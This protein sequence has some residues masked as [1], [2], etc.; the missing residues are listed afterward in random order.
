[1]LFLIHYIVLRYAGKYRPLQ[2]YDDQY[3]QAA[4]QLVS[5]ELSFS[6]QLL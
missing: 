6:Q 3:V 1:M 4:E 2:R 5:Q